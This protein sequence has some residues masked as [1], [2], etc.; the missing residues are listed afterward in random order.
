MNNELNRR[1][2]CNAENAK[3]SPSPLIMANGAWALL[4][5]DAEQDVHKSL[6][7]WVETCRSKQTVI[8]YLLHCKVGGAL[9]G[10]PCIRHAWNLQLCWHVILTWHVTTTQN[11]CCMMTIPKANADDN[12]I[13]SLHYRVLSFSMYFHR[14]LNI[15]INSRMTSS[16]NFWCNSSLCVCEKS[17]KS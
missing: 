5:D 12:I 10:K 14:R 8:F 3:S 13:T 7:L 4:N 2:V 15:F 11:K 6:G 16:Q 17:N 1:Y 9:H